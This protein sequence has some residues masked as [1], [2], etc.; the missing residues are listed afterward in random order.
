MSL[1]DA[2]MLS[3]VGCKV[4]YITSKSAS[5]TTNEFL[6][7][8]FD[9]IQ[10]ENV[11][12]EVG[13]KPKYLNVSRFLRD[14]KSAI[15]QRPAP[16]DPLVL[17]TSVLND[18]SLRKAKDTA[19][20][21]ITRDVRTD[22]DAAI[23]EEVESLPPPRRRRRVASATANTSG[24]CVVCLS[25]PANTAIKPCFHACFCALCA[26]KVVSEGASPTCPICRKGV[27]GTQRIFL[28]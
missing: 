1:E 5:A 11:V 24:E 8:G 19:A 2:K 23:E 12:I 10:H 3:L 16:N 6:V 15:I 9:E 18:G 7:T 25:E 14:N 26:A 20:K 17:A 28:A 22:K 4:I 13:T 21:K 27:T